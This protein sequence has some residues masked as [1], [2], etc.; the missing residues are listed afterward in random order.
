MPTA[1]I[2]TSEITSGARARR[3]AVQ[4]IPNNAWTQV[5]LNVETWD[6]AGEFDPAV[7][8]DFTSTLG[9]YYTIDAELTLPVTLADCRVGISIYLNGAFFRGQMFYAG[10]AGNL[11]LSCSALHNLSAADVIELFVMQVSGGAV[12]LID[13]ELVLIRIFPL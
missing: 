4:N 6:I 1:F 9:G 10:G 3:T 8:F 11:I 5:Q 2:S 7:G 13:A 12:N